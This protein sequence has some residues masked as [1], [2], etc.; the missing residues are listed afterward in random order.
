MKHLKDGY[1]ISIGRKKSTLVNLETR[2]EQELAFRDIHS[3]Q[4]LALG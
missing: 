4:A 3:I 1:I 2:D